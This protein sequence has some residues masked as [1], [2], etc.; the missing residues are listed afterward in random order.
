MRL[1]EI[2]RQLCHNKS[3]NDS[4]KGEAE[5]NMKISEAIEHQSE[6]LRTQMAE[7]FQLFPKD[8]NVMLRTMK[9]GSVFIQEDTPSVTVYVLLSGRVAAF[10]NQPGQ[11]Q[12]LAMHDV[13]LTILGDLAPLGNIPYHTTSMRTY[14]KT[15]FLTMRRDTSLRWTDIDNALYRKLVLHNLNML[16]NQAMHSRSASCQPTRQRILEYLCWY[17]EVERKDSG[18]TVLIRKTREEITEDLGH[19]SLRT[20]NRYISE[21]EDVG[22]FSIVRGKIQIAQKQYEKIVQ[23]RK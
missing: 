16:M 22:L 4:K 15:Y 8:E 1:L 3:K 9:S 2:L 19:I 6:P 7:M 5:S 18:T 11:S 21:L 12:F 17:Y 14:T 10:W 13:P 23:Y 20:L